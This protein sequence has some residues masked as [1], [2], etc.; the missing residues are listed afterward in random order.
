[1]GFNAGG[2]FWSSYSLDPL[3]GE[4]FGAAANPW[5]DWSRDVAPNDIAGT[6]TTNSRY[7][8]A[9]ISA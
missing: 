8:P 7:Q 9:P 6:A 3:T 2:G 1:L 4:A 5:P